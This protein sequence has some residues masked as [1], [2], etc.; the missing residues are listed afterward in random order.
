[1]QKTGMNDALANFL[2]EPLVRAQQIETL[3]FDYNQMGSSFL[4]KYCRKMAMIGFSANL[5]GPNSA[6]AGIDRNA[7]ASILASE[8]EDQ[9]TG[10]ASQSTQGSGP[11]GLINF[12]LEGNEIGDK[13]AEAISCMI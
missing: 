1:M 7:S 3:K 10:R 13:G 8:S 5:H 9:L 12:S 2:V 6:T 4:D 11:S